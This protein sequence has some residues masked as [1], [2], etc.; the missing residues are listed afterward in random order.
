M[1]FRENVVRYLLH[2]S[3]HC[4]C[5]CVMCVYHVSLLYAPYKRNK[6][7]T[8]FRLNSQLTLTTKRIT[9]VYDN[10]IGLGNE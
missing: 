5:S 4:C 1:D 3:R 9:N 8:V 2:S 10:S 7:I 6:G